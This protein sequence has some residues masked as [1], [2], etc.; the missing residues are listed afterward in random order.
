MNVASRTPEP[1]KSNSKIAWWYR[2]LCDNATVADVAMWHAHGALE[3]CI[4]RHH[5]VENWGEKGGRPK[6]EALLGNSE[7]GLPSGDTQ[8]GRLQQ[9]DNLVQTIAW[10]K[11]QANSLFYI[12]FTTT[13]TYDP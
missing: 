1:S 7:A 5:M 6:T 12:W 10:A 3:N 11:A 2:L 4:S 13:D 8:I 9:A